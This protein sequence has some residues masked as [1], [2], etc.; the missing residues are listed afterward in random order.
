M[1][2]STRISFMTVWTL[3]KYILDIYTNVSKYKP[4]GGYLDSLDAQNHVIVFGF[5]G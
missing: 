1:Q 5:F 2:K 3:P 4:S